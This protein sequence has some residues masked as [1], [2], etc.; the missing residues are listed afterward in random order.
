M[1]CSRPSPSAGE[2]LKELRLHLG[3]STRKVEAKSQQIADKQCNREFRVPHAWVTDVEHNRFN[4][5][6]FK[7][8]SLS[9]IY[10]VTY[11]ELLCYFGI[12]MGGAADSRYKG[13]PVTRGK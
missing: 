10:S 5:S 4:P 11:A 3:L 13:T 9:I 8:Y 2:K 12:Q 7:L 1:V 6:I